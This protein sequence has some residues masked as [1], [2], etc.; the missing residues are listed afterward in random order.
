MQKLVFSFVMW[1]IF[2]PTRA[3]RPVVTM[4][5]QNF[6][7][8]FTVTVFFL[9]LVLKNIEVWFQPTVKTLG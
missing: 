8:S 2:V 4:L 7:S 1:T 9:D 6:I 3:S 5:I